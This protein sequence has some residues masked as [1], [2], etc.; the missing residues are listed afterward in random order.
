MKRT[1]ASPSPASPA[2]SSPRVKPLSRLAPTSRKGRMGGPTA[3]DRVLVAVRVRPL[4]GNDAVGRLTDGEGETARSAVRGDS[5]LNAVECD[6][7]RSKKKD[8]TYDYVFAEGQEEI[9]DCIGK[10]MLREAFNGYNVC[11]FAYGQTGSGKTYTIQGLPGAGRPRDAPYEQ[12]HEGVVPR[13]CRDLFAIVQDLLDEDESLSIK[14]TLSFAEVYNEKVRDLLPVQRTPKG[15]EPPSLEIHETPDHR[16]EVRG[17]AKHTVIGSEK[18]L[19]FIH[20]GNMNRQVAETKMNECSSRSHSILQLHMVQ[21]YEVPSPDKRDCESYINIVDL[22]GSE[23]QSKTGAQGEQFKEATHINHSLLMLGRALNS[24]SEKGEKAQHVPLRESKLTRI[25]SES[26]GGNSKTW[27][28]ATVSPSLY[29]WSETLSTLN[30]ASAAKNITN[31][32]KQ[33]RLQRA[34]EMKELKDLNAKLQASLDSAK[35]DTERLERM[36]E[37]LRREKA[38]LEKQADPGTMQ[39]LKEDN[40]RLLDERN[41]LKQQLGELAAGLEKEK[42]EKA[43]KEQAVEEQRAVM[44]ATPR[45]G[46]GRALDGSTGA[47]PAGLTT[48]QSGM[49]IGRAKV[50]LKNIIEQTSNYLTL[51]LSNESG[52]DGARGAVLVVNIY[53]VDAKG[54]AAL[55]RKIQSNEKDLLGQRVDFVVHIIGAKGI[56]KA[57]SDTVYCK[58][59]YKWAE[60][61]SYKTTDVHKATEPEFDFKKRFAFSKMNAGL[62]EYFRSDNV[63]TFEV[64]GIAAP[65]PQPAS[66]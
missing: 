56:P 12:G 10:Q 37:Q 27:M 64:I 26:F 45:P 8:F 33:N 6:D 59:V 65:E 5:T 3:A 39:R 51:P 63:I 57:Y 31:T 9:Y 25:L 46:A 19:D 61:D 28:L 22:A 15:Q 2:E 35:R 50:S 24:F 41:E 23:R 52:V 13:L 60:K 58:Y 16:I 11:L 48:P 53:P 55:D 17:L 4:L 30:Y 21:Q 62:V 29:N 47:I 32:A 20:K 36:M 44:Q 54:S 18:V 66:R 38:E 43:A 49:Y 1:P 40:A 34:M 42:K 7:G 14:V